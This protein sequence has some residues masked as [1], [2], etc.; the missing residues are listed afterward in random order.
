VKA[1]GRV[2]SHRRRSRRRWPRRRW[3]WLLGGGRVL[4]LWSAR[5]RGRKGEGGFRE[6]GFL[7]GK[8]YGDFQLFVAPL[9]TDVQPLSRQEYLGMLLGGGGVRGTQIPSQELHGTILAKHTITSSRTG[10]SHRGGSFAR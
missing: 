1:R 5:R 4:R 6:A 3:Q 7:V 9:H 8:L 10:R 2:E